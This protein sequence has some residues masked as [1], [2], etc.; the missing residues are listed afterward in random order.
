MENLRSGISGMASMTKS[1]SESESIDSCGLRR[2]LILSDWSCVILSFATSFA[3]NLSVDKL[4]ISTNKERALSLPANLSP[5]SIEAWLV[6]TR[7]TG[8]PALDAATRAIPSPY[9]IL[10]KSPR[11]YL[12]DGCELPFV[13]RL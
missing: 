8:T 2:D 1:T 11:I 6:S 4:A 12:F 5:L 13:Q 10:A 3:S 9:A 7:V